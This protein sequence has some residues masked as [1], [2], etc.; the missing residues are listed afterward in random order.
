MVMSTSHARRFQLEGYL[1]V[2]RFLAPEVCEL[3]SRY[4]RMKQHVE[5]GHV[6]AQVPRFAYSVYGDTLMESLTETVQ[7]RIEAIIEEPLWPTYTY[8]RVYET[9][10]VLKPHMDRGSCEVSVSI[11][12]GAYYGEAAPEGTNW[13]LWVRSFAGHDQ[14]CRMLPGD[15]VIYQGCDLLHWREAYQGEWQVQVFLHFVR[16]KGPFATLAKYDCR[17][18]LG[19]PVSTRDQEQCAKLVR[20][21]RLRYHTRHLRLPS[22]ATM[23]KR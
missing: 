18:A 21:E 3:A 23:G 12:L 10:A 1:C 20:L 15:L 6:D 22:T 9:S 14:A 16:Q 7:P 11:C 2:E 4:A 13:P 8:Y 19:M 17:P 5:P